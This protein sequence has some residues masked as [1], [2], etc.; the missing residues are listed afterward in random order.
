EELPA[1]VGSFDG[2]RGGLVGVPDAHDGPTV[3]V[4]VGQDFAAGGGFSA[5]VVGAV[6]RP[7]GCDPLIEG[8]VG[9]A[10]EAER[11]SLAAVEPDVVERAGQGARAAL[12]P[13]V[14]TGA[15]V[16]HGVGDGD[17][18]PRV[19]E[20]HRRPAVVPGVRDDE[21]LV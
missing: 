17:R 2:D 11:L 10:V 13:E 9:A 8:E 15:G 6:G 7:G 20:L 21:V 1:L 5:G 19:V 18:C 3:D 14:P 16:Q 12:V 4:V